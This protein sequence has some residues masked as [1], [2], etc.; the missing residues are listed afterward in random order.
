MQPQENLTTNF[1]LFHNLQNYDS[2]LI[3]QE[4]QKYNFKKCVIPEQL[5]KM[6][7]LLASILKGILLLLDFQ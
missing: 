6:Q 3:I 1:F 2:H 4:I 5:K 7:A